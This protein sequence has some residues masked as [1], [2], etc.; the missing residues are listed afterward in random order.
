MVF[1]KDQRGSEVILG[2][3]DRPESELIAVVKTERSKFIEINGI[4]ASP[5]LLCLESMV[6]VDDTSVVNISILQTVH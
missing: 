1:I 2:C 4:G 3:Q 6:T 5:S